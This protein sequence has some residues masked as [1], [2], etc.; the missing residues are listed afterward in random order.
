MSRL[1][2]FLIAAV[3]TVGLAGATLAQPQTEPAPG[4]TTSETG[5]GKAA[6]KKMSKDERQRLKAERRAAMKAA[7]AKLT[8]QERKALR[9]RR[10]DCRAQ[11]KQD[12][13]KGKKF[14]AYVQT[15]LKG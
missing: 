13:L 9:A 1:S 15:C 3:L 8:P 6:K 12:G 2:S 7:A 14:R 11:G 4:A 10:Q 5:A